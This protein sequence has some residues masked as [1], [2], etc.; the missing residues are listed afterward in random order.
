MSQ[1]PTMAE[2][3]E[4]LEEARRVV[5]LGGGEA[6]IAKQ[7]D[8]GKLTARERI[9]ALVD[10]GTFH[11]TGMFAKHRTTHF[12]MDKAVAPA[13]GVVTGSGAVF[14]RPLHIASQD[15]TVMG[16]SA[17]ETQSNKVAA[18]MEAS[19]TTGTPFIFINDSG[20]ARVQEGIDS[21]SGY[22]KVFYQNVLLSGLVPQISIIAGPCAGGAAYSPAL[23]DFII[24]T[25]K[26]NMFITG[27][28]VIK[29]VTGEDVTADQLGGADAHMAKAGN[30]HFVADDDEQAILIAQKL[31]SF[32]PQNN[33]EEPP[34][35]DPDPIVEPDLEL[36][37]IVPVEGK[38]GY[39]V[40][41]VI[42]RVV[43]RGDFLEVQA[44]YA[45]N[46]VVGFA[47]VVG[48]TVG[49]IAN[50]PNVMSGVLDIN[51]SD[52]GSQFI[53]FCN[54]FNIPLVTFVDVPGFMPGVA[55][56]HG[57]IIRHGA[58]MLYAY[59]AATVPKITIELRKSYGGAH[60]AMCSKDLGADR[61]FAWPTAEIA[62]MGAEGAVNVVF[63]KEIAEAEDPATK[64][65]ELIRLYKETFSTPFMA[66][67]R[68][69][70]D[71]I[72]DPAETRLHIA[73]ALEVLANKRVTRPAKKH[74]LGPV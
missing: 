43:D 48:R 52:K 55:Q 71:D 33:T 2:R 26:A 24:Q 38:K 29:S 13:D 34:I 60:L 47:R 14:G 59:S 72:I 63:R 73:D 42:T 62:V 21:L 32:L 66:A 30:I 40:R 41:E 58:K 16:G 49:I 15:F 17:G 45:Q 61:V 69:L 51:S 7:H 37:D 54:A 12:G 56:E 35:V 28:G 3:L 20:G 19:A 22:G 67:S 70:V 46:L 5:S 11:E 27:P 36:R 1:E 74:G 57:G 8:Q 18:M 10:E 64:R 4:Q 23:T 44:G 25:R 65:E 31:L 68:G 9:E 39:D 6:K 50:Q 53:R